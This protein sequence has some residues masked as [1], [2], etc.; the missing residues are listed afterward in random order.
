VFSI[1]KPNPAAIQ[2]IMLLHTTMLADT[3]SIL[4][5]NTKY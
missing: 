3:T 2:N 5:I 4:F 1:S